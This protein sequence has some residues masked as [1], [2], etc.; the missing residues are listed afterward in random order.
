MEQRCYLEDSLPRDFIRISQVS[1]DL[2]VSPED[3]LE[4]LKSDRP[5]HAASCGAA[6]CQLPRHVT[7]H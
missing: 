5:F 3:F 6:C 2:L 1:L 7:A 4:G